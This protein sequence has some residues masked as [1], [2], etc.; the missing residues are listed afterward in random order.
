MHFHIRHLL[1]L[2]TTI[3]LIC[4]FIRTLPF[5]VVLAPSI[6]F[7]SNYASRAAQR[8]DSRI[9]RTLFDGGLSAFLSTLLF[10]LPLIVYNVLFDYFYAGRTST[11]NTTSIGIHFLMTITLAG[12]GMTIGVLI[13]ICW[14]FYHLFTTHSRIQ[15][16]RGNNV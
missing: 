1:L 4:A 6:L 2:M 16:W 9:E 5:V 8:F 10:S 15:G 3:A 7:G 11:L 12:F 13:G 14:H